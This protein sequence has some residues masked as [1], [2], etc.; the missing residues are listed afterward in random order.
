M[1]RVGNRATVQMNTVYLSVACRPELITWVELF[2][3][4]NYA[5]ERNVEKFAPLVTQ[6]ANGDLLRV[7]NGFDW[8]LWIAI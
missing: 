1:P 8:I 5:S 7:T 3:C 2:L 6:R 4:A